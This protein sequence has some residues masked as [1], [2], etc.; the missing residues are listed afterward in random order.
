[1]NEITKIHLGRQAFTVSVDAH[2][3]LQEYLRAIKKHMVDSSEAVEE[4]ELRMAELLVE[5]KISGNKVV[6]LKDVEYLKAQLGEPGDFGDDEETETERE[7]APAQKRLFR[8]TKHALI[9]GVAAG[10]ATYFGVKPAVFR[11]IFVV[12]LLSVFGG[13]FNFS[14][15][16]GFWAI[17]LLYIILWITVPEANSGSDR[18]Q[19]QGKPVTVDAIKAAVERADVKGAASRAHH[20]VERVANAI[21]KITLGV[22]GFGLMLAGIAALFALTSLGVYWMLN[23]DFVP[24]GIF[25]VDTSEVVLICLAFV[26]LLMVALFFVI[27]GLAVTKRKWPLPSWGL[28]AIVAVFLAS[29]AVGGALV[30]D[31]VPKI[32]QRHDAANHTYTRSLPEF[33]K[34]TVLGTFTS[35]VRYENAA[36]NAVVVKYWGNT[37]VSDIKTE[38]KDQTL[39]VDVR[40]LADRTSCKQQFCLFRPQ[41]REIVVKGPNLQEVTVDMQGSQLTLPELQ[42]QTLLVRALDSTIFMPGFTADA[43]TAELLKDNFWKLTFAGDKTDEA[44]DQHASI[45]ERSLDT[46]ARN[47]DLTFDGECSVMYGGPNAGPAIVIHGFDVLNVNGKKFAS[48]TELHTALDQPGSSPERCVTPVG[49][50]NDSL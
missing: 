33:N 31:A 7:E 21:S 49:M 30:A 14:L 37:E 38:V 16:G 39:T 2:K 36:T 25:P 48:P 4:V 50:A 19:M 27:T 35:N 32:K 3:S 5:R 41:I 26:S 22:V 24:A 9:A 13:I 28:G 17:A 20:I 29:L 10:L 34:L 8:D 18:L 42:N 12:G 6:L 47:I 11:I 1:M 43:F 44:Y 40:S 46:H 23:H 15:T 45:Y